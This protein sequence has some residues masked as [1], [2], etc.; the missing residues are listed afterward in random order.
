MINTLFLVCCKYRANNV[1]VPT[2]SSLQRGE[3]EKQLVVGVWAFGTLSNGL[4]TLTFLGY[5]DSA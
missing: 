3:I 1:P 4:P 5:L 2:N